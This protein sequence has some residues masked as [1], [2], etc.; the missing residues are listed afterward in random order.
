MVVPVHVSVCCT[1]G[2]VRRPGKCMH[3]AMT[4][5]CAADRSLGVVDVSRNVSRLRAEHL[6]HIPMAVTNFHPFS[7][8]TALELSSFGLGNL[9]LLPN[10]VGLVSPLSHAALP[11]HAQESGALLHQATREDS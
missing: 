7:E 5:P 11:C 10:L 9:A 2:N 4:E 3:I 1:V 6:P 8:L